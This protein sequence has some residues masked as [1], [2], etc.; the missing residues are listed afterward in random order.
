MIEL[1][2]GILPYKRVKA[3]HVEKQISVSGVLALKSFNPRLHSTRFT[4]NR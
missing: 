1:I 2:N 4:S 3:V